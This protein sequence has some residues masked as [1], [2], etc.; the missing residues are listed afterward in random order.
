MQHEHKT[1]TLQA[2]LLFMFMLCCV[3]SGVIL[4]EDLLVVR[5]CRFHGNEA[6]L[7]ALEHVE[8]VDQGLLLGALG[9]NKY[10][11]SFSGVLVNS[12]DF[13]EMKQ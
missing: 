13:R 12:S 10:V 1:A 6:L 4:L 3:V 7:A 11:G 5:C 9:K 2:L 8:G